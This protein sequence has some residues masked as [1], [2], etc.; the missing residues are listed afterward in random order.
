MTEIL[1]EWKR[2]PLDEFL[3]S[4][5]RLSR[6]ALDPASRIDALME[7]FDRLLRSGFLPE[8]STSTQP[9]RFLQYLVFRPDDRAYS[10]M[11]MAVAPGVRTPIHDHLAWGLVGVY[12]GEQRET[13]YE[14]T[15]HGSVDA[16]AT[17]CLVEEKRLGVAHITT[18]LPPTGDI[19][20]IRTVSGIPSVSLHLLGNDIGCQA[21]HA[22]DIETNRVADFRSGYVNADCDPQ[23]AD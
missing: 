15:D 4:V 13:V 5:E 7:P 10:L 18:L 17:L 19:H 6:L 3:P 14:R 16:N 11:A 22:Y 21:R 12:Q 8:E 9:G 1:G 2:D 23:P 20:Q